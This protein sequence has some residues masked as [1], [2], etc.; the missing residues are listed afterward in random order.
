MLKVQL[1]Y[2]DTVWRLHI[3]YILRVQKSI[4]SRFELRLKLIPLCLALFFGAKWDTHTSKDLTVYQK[5]ILN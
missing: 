4:I 1:S 5:K 2:R 3:T